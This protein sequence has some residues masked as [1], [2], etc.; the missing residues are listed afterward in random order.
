M[1]TLL[2][3]S[4]FYGQA[5][6]TNMNVLVTSGHC[7]PVSS[8]TAW[9][10]PW[11]DTPA[12][13]NYYK[14]TFSSDPNGTDGTSDAGYI[15]L[16]PGFNV[17][18]VVPYPSSTSMTPMIGYY[19]NNLVGDTVYLRGANSGGTTSGTIKYSNVDVWWGSKGYA[20]KEDEVFVQGFTSIQG[21]SGGPILAGYRWDNGRGKYVW[22]LAGINT[23]LV[24]LSGYAP[25]IVDGTYNVYEKVARVMNTLDLAGAYLAP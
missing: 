19:T 12:F 5:N 24:T 25:I 7:S 1:K 20:Y 23:G 10:Q 21:D 4:G 8:G 11:Y 22:D 13:G 16:Y 6:T 9:Y 15:A 18:P 17:N 14:R 3:T 2:S